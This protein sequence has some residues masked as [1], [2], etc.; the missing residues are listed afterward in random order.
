[1]LLLWQPLI[2]LT[3]CMCLEKKS[4][5]KN[6][7]FKNP[8]RQN[9]SHQNSGHPKFKPPKIQATKK[10]IISA[11]FQF[12]F[13]LQNAFQKSSGKNFWR[14]PAWKNQWAEKMPLLQKMEQNKIGHYFSPGNK[15][16][17]AASGGMLLQMLSLR[18]WW[19]EFLVAWIF[20]GLNFWWLESV[21]SAL[22]IHRGARCTYV[23]I[24]EH[25]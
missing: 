5:L 20:G 14:C 4:P 21:V 7:A 23:L 18:L 19:L 15:G 25:S 11:L 10:C 22:I 9:S 16:H 8:S 2:C 24:T 17:P 3:T 13:F 1:M 12:C 6:Q